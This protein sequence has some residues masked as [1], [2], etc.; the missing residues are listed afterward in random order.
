MKRN[1]LKMVLGLAAMVV[2]LVGLE[3]QAS[4][5][6]GSC[7]SHGGRGGLLVAVAMADTAVCGSH[8][9]LFGRH[10][11]G[12]CCGNSSSCEEKKDCEAKKKEVWRL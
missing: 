12:G 5:G 9:G 11:N 2:V 1:V 6:H 7:G 4:A 10:R 3:S 8:G